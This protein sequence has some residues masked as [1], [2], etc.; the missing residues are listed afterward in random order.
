MKKE[1]DTVLK[2]M[3][4]IVNRDC[5]SKKLSHEDSKEKIDSALSFIKDRFKAHI[6]TANSIEYI[7]AKDNFALFMTMKDLRNYSLPK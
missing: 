7:K 4:G 1:L 2:L 3:E 6:E 5:C